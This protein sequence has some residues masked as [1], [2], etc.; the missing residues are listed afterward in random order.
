V[1]QRLVIAPLFNGVGPTSPALLR[2]Y[3]DPVKQ[4]VCL[5]AAL[6]NESAR[7]APGKAVHMELG[8]ASVIVLS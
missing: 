7:R 3:D 2:G 1:S 4:A 5:P 8:R 6:S